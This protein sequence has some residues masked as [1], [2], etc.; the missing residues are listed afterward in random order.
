M[1]TTGNHYLDG[2]M[3]KCAQYNVD[4]VNLAEFAKQANLLHDAGDFADDAGD[5]LREKGEK[6]KGAITDVMDSGDGLM[7]NVAERTEDIYTNLRRG[8]QDAGTA[9]SRKYEDATTALGRTGEDISTG[10]ERFS[11]SF[12]SRTQSLLNKL[13]ELFGVDA[14][15]PSAAQEE[16]NRQEQ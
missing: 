1:E 16:L 15:K 13:K 10:F 7:D 4:P 8:A 2:F 6:V 12:G 9:A 14:D 11:E 5:Y 3:S